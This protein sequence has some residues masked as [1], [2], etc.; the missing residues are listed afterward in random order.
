MSAIIGSDIVVVVYAGRRGVA[1][2]YVRADRLVWMKNSDARKPHG[3]A[4]L[5][6]P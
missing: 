3:H 2:C 6:A 4:G 1:E 5:I